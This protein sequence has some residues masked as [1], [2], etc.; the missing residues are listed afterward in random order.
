MSKSANQ[1]AEELAEAGCPGDGKARNRV[2]RVLEA[3]LIESLSALWAMD[4]PNT[5]L[6]HERLKPHE[7]DFLAGLISKEKQRRSFAREP[8]AQGSRARC[9]H[10]SCKFKRWL[11][12]YYAGPA[13]RSVAASR[14]RKLWNLTQ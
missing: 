5:W 3:N 14:S 8:A 13:A 2:A 7:G 11:L 10:T 4:M 1:L 6:L 12:L 9:V